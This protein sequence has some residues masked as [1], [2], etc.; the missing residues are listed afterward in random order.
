MSGL[1]E[2]RNEAITTLDEYSRISIAFPVERVFD[3]EGDNT[4]VERSVPLPWVKD[5]DAEGTGPTT[6]LDRFDL[7]NWGCLTAWGPAGRAGGALVAW[8]TANVT[9]LEGRSDLAVLWDLRVVPSLR[10]TGV[11]S[12]LFAAA[13][14]WARSKGCLEL[15]VETQNVNVAACRFYRRHGCR[16]SS[17]R[18]GAY[19]SAQNE[20]QLIW[21][22]TL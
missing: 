3:V 12:A 6:L 21:R 15:K 1:T 9:M 20:I 19:S 13:V 4:L 17:A 14:A 18:S 2:I 22:K 7:S 8:N 5:Y 10:R 11:G 16:L